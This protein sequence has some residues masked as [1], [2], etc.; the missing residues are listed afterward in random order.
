VSVA[1][2][3]TWD[4]ATWPDDA[5]N[6]PTQPV[7]LAHYATWPEA[8]CER[9]IKAMCPQ[10][11]CTV[12]G[13]PSRRI[14]K[15]SDEYDAARCKGDFLGKSNDRDIGMQGERLNGR[16]N[17]EYVTLGW[18]DCGCHP[19][20]VQQ[21]SGSAEPGSSQPRNGEPAS[22][23]GSTP[24]SAPSRWRTGTV[25]DPFAGSGTTLAVALGH[26][27]HAIGIDL[28]QRNAELARERVGMFLTVEYPEVVA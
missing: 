22:H 20:V 12:C 23:L 14:T 7:K 28:D 27:R 9:P 16:P 13:E 15:P 25:L 10:R 18:T 19:P 21:P 17:A 24:G 5:W 8:L 26:G 11:V 3:S 4:Y 2:E 1:S 6:I